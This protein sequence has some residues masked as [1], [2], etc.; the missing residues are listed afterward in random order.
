MRKRK[1]RTLFMGILTVLCSV[2]ALNTGQECTALAAENVFEMTPG[3]SIRLT[4]SYGLRFQVKMSA[5]VK[6]A[7]DEVGMLIFPADYLVDNGTKGDIYYESVEELAATTVSDHR[8]K[9]DLTRKL[10][11]KDGYWYGNG[12]IVDIEDKNMAREFVGIAYYEVDGETVWADISKIAGTT[13]SAAQIALLAHADETSAYPTETDELL[14]NYVGYTKDSNLKNVQIGA[15]PLFVDNGTD[16][17]KSYWKAEYVDGGVKVTVDVKDTISIDSND[18]GYSDNIEL[19]MQ[20]VDNHWK[21]KGSTFNFLCSANGRYW[22]RRW[23]GYGYDAVELA[24]QDFTYSCNTTDTGYQVE[25]FVSYGALNVTEEEGKGNVRICPMLRN[26]SDSGDNVCLTSELLGCNWWST[27][28]WLVLNANN[29]F[30]HSYSEQFTLDSINPV[31][32]NILADLATLKAE[33]GG[34]MMKTEVG[35][36]AHPNSSWCIDGIANDLVNTN[37]VFAGLEASATVKKSGYVVV[38]VSD[39]NTALIETLQTGGWE[40][41]A[42]KCRAAI[43]VN[44]Y[45]DGAL[46]STTS[47]YAKYCPAGETI[48]TSGVY[49]LVFGKGTVTS[50]DMAYE[51]TP[52]Y[53]SFSSVNADYYM[54][55]N[56][57]MN[58]MPSVA[59]TNNGRIY[60]VYMTG[61]DGEYQMKNSGI[62]K[63]SDDDGKTWNRLFVID[64]WDNQKINSTKQTVCSDYEL[65]IDPSTNVL[66]VTYTLRPNANGVL[67]MDTQTWMFTISNPDSEVMTEEALDISEHWN[68]KLG[69]VRNGFTVL[70]NGDFIIVPNETKQS[71]KNSVYISKDKGETWN[72]IG[73]IYI[74]QATYHDEPVVVEKQDGSLWCLTCSNT[75]YLTESFSYDGGKT[76]TVG[77]QTEIANPASRFAISRL[78]SG[79]LIMVSNNDS[80]NKIGMVVAISN[81]D[82]ATW[83]D[84]LCLF[85]GY[86]SY[87]T[88]ALDNSTGKEQIHVVF[89]D[90]RYYYGQWRTGVEEGTKYEYYGEIYHDVLTEDE[91]LAGGDP[92]ADE[93]ELLFVGD[94]YTDRPWCLGFDNALGTYGADTIG[95]GGTEVYQWNNEEKLAEVVAKNPKNLFINLGINNIGNAGED[96]ETVGNQVVAYLEALKAKLPNTEIYYNLLVY[97][98]T[99]WHDYNSI[100]TSNAI[101]EAYIDGDTTDK[102]HKIDIREAIKRCG[103][104]DSAK[105]N[106]GLH[107][108][109]PGYTLL[110]DALKKEIGFGRRA[111]D[112]NIV[113]CIGKEVSKYEWADWEDNMIDSDAPTRYKVRGYAADDGIYFNAVQYVNNLVTT[114][115]DWTEQTHLELEMYNWNGLNTGSDN[116]WAYGAFWLDGNYYLVNSDGKL[117]YGVTFVKNN[118]T[119]TDR[120]ADY[121][122]GYQ[123]KIS[124]EVYIQFANNTG[125]SDGPYA[126]VHFRHHMPG[127]EGGFENSYYEHRDVDTTADRYLWRDHYSSY[128]FRKVGIIR[129]DGVS[130]FKTNLN[131]LNAL[132]NTWVATEKGFYSYSVGDTFALSQTTATDFIYEADVLFSETKGAASLVF[133][134]ADDPTT[135]SYVANVDKTNQLFRVFKFPGGA[136]VCTAPLKENKDEY[137]L[138]VE[139]VGDL[140]KFYVDGELVATGNDSTYT[141]GK[142]GLLTWYS[143]VTY[144]NV[145]YQEIN[146]EDVP[147]LSDLS[148]TG[149]DVIFTPDYN[150]NLA[151]Y[152]AYLPAGTDEMEVVA[153]SAEGTTLAYVL[154]S[155]NGVTYDSGALE[156][157]TKKAIIPS[158]G[159]STMIINATKGELT[160]SVT[161]KITNKSDKS[162]MAE[163][164]YRPQLHFTPEINFMN[165]PNGL[166]YDPSNGTWHMFFQYSPQLVTMGSQTWGHAVSDDLVN[167]VELPVA[168]EMDDFGAVFSG[169]CVVDENN[170]SG[171]FTDN[172]E[173]ESKLV[174]MYTSWGATATQNIAYSKDH[175][176]TWTKYRPA[177]GQPVI[178]DNYHDGIRDPK[179]FKIAGDEKNLWYMVIAGGRGR[180]FVSENLRE[181]TLLQELTYADGSELH[182]EC[183]ELYSLEVLDKDGN[184]TGES[185][186]VYS[187]SSEFYII[188]DMV[189]GDDG[190]YRF[191][192]EKRIDSQTG[193]NSNAYAAQSY[194]NDPV[195]G[196]RI[197]VHWMQDWSAP[198]TI[199]GKRW[200]GVQ[201]FPLETTLKVINGGYTVVQNPVEEVKQL[202]GDVLY[203]KKNITVSESSDNILAGITGQVYEIE[204]VFSNFSEAKEFGFELRTGNG[205]TTV[206]KYNVEKETVTLDK[207]LSGVYDNDVL[208]WVLIPR[209]DGTVKLRAIVDKSII[210]TFGNDGEAHLI[211]MLF[212][213]ESSVGMSFYT[214]GGPVTI[215]EITV[216]DMKSIYTGKSVTSGETETFVSLDARETVKEGAGFTV[217]ANIFPM[218]KFETVEWILPSG[219]EKVSETDTSITLKADEKGI[220]TISAKI[221]GK[222]VSVE[223]QA[224]DTM[225]DVIKGDVDGNG[226]LELADLELLQSFVEGTAE[227]EDWQKTAGDLD[228]D[229]IFTV[230]DVLA[231]QSIVNATKLSYVDVANGLTD[232]TALANVVENGEKS[233]ESSAYDK[234]SRYNEETGQYEGWFAD[235]DWGYDSPSNGDGGIIAAEMEGPG[236]LT[237]IWSASPSDGHV[238]IWVDGK[239]AIDMPF[240]DLFGT[241]AYPFNLSE[242]CYFAGRGANCYVP[243]TYN[244]SCK[245][246]LYEGWGQYFQINYLTYGE[247]TSVESFELPLSSKATKALNAV[248]VQLAGDLSALVTTENT[249]E[250]TVTV[251]AG[252][253]VDLLNVKEAAAITNMTIKINDLDMTIGTD[254]VAHDW[255]ALSDMVLS[256]K[257]DQEETES[258]WSTLGGFFASQTGLNEYSSISS[259][260]LEDGTMYSNW[261]MPYETGAIVT[262]T[263]DGD[264]DYSI[265]YTI[266]KDALE[267]EEAAEQMRFHAKWMRA[268]DPVFENNDRWPDTPFLELQGSG[269]YVGTSLHVYKPIGY[270]DGLGNG[271]TSYNPVNGK[272]ESIYPSEWWWGEGDEKFFVDGEKFPS[273]FGTGVEDYFGYAWGTWNPFSEAYHSQPFTNGGMWGTGNRLN[274]RFHVLDNVPFAESLE[275]CLEK[276]HRDEY[277]TWAFTNFFYLDHSKAYTDPYGPVSLEERTAYY[278]DPYP[279]AL[280]FDSNNNAIVEGEHLAIVDATGMCQAKQ[281]NMV[282]FGDGVWS[283]NEQV[284]FI[285]Y[286][287]DNSVRFYLNIEEEGD[288]DLSAVFTK[289]G[290][291]GIYQHYIDG[292]EVGGNIDIYVNDIWNNYVTKTSE[293]YMG[294]AHLTAGVH[295][296]EARCVGKNSQSTGYVYGMDYLKVS[297]ASTTHV[298]EGEDQYITSGTATY[299]YQGGMNGWSYGRH[300]LQIN[301]GVG[302]HVAF[303][304]YVN[305]DGYY[306]IR[307]ALTKAVDFSIVQHYIDDEEIGPE[308]DLYNNGVIPTGEISLGHVYLTKGTHSFKAVMVDKNELSTGYLYGLDYLKVSNAVE[309]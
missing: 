30:V 132:Q 17:A 266:A 44:G 152:S 108:S 198:W 306:D 7:A 204:A 153:T 238:K 149:T 130:N 168:I 115:D 190:Y 289:A 254:G 71:A 106:D 210:E 33:N 292:E 154:K 183:P 101:V 109:A 235:S 124:Y 40:L 142:L 138:R 98:T 233:W 228:G 66:Y 117:P 283:N 309:E 172:K 72:A 259:G 174:A 31:A 193:G 15:I 52:A 50:S 213:D 89:D 144:Q 92:N 83:E 281:Q 300:L 56:N 208:S 236:V 135:G 221:N 268:E 25:L 45:N 264:E 118:V 186:W 241:G 85:D 3:G 251:K 82:G 79:K 87:P 162:V 257:W 60:A 274:N 249:I 287:T 65:K 59:V 143:T 46:S 288:Y 97:P 24:A 4:E 206:Y 58:G 64:T 28:S 27:K 182:S 26:R 196:R 70:K 203:N 217:T 179:I 200:N 8:I 146:A 86:A 219:I 29:K 47:Y 126:Y 167:W 296:L 187:A 248:N 163:E 136:N 157:G 243:I 156:S 104:A 305:E 262:V 123:Y 307:A 75:G 61:S 276:Y 76:W 181:W 246:V 1:F 100:T 202:R 231:L 12:A 302:D 74:P 131:S 285:A 282:A 54:E 280:T 6:G 159:A 125:S 290:D 21:T 308:V 141:S 197:T 256:M 121:E 180:I 199:P 224:T 19:Q 227:P 298:Y 185:K 211:D 99:G 195:S 127:E 188:G 209:S 270:G 237:R 267:P 244:E 252:E 5:D 297:K 18:V 41:L 294:Y 191:Q 145:M 150:E 133:R 173:G 245:V 35:N 93:L 261:Y 16:T 67:P 258:V 253:S 110:F 128:E 301:N 239:L 218:D 230:A 225:V 273:W 222:E 271:L 116:G 166:V 229:G 265:T 137:H 90:G 158:C 176:V 175:G 171:F 43:G 201:S 63:Y 223:V 48:T 216:Y 192:A 9:L 113:S 120:G 165:D 51:T 81:D 129:R 78:T 57:T 304:I 114:G 284:V 215:D 269:R 220:Y 105:F 205:Q 53:H 122:D 234:A 11:K 32:S 37:Y 80:S 160:S 69:Y 255:K 107:M 291:F 189:K 147:V 10:Y 295:I 232:L 13:R 103:E 112:L 49:S 275:A 95:I 55:E 242:L 140:I 260:V 164:A 36:Q 299:G 14:L 293:I 38:C 155:E 286:G 161:I 177:V 278:E 212:A 277:A 303:N 272:T 119:I 170:T 73:S 151:S 91:I 184:P 94:S 62:V 20:A 226:R 178:P 214:V 111:E 88:I 22:T 68:T 148:V 102:V 247:N 39:D 42:G 84:K 77:T 207:S 279:A 263:N 169:S 23:N 34:K 240:K 250:N 194:Y 96:D 2:F 134:S 139:A